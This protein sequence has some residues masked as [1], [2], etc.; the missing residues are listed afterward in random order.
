ML[1]DLLC[2]HLS[3]HKWGQ[4]NLD[5]EA[6]AVSQQVPA[7]ALHP[8]LEPRFCSLYMSGLL[9]GR[10]LDYAYGGYLEDRSFLL[11]QSYL[12][13]GSMIHLG[14]DYMVAAGTR[15]F[16][17]RTAKV[18]AFEIDPDQEGGWGG[19]AILATPEVIYVICHLN[20]KA[21][22][23]RYVGQELEKGSLVGFTGKTRENGGWWPHIHIQCLRPEMLPELLAY[24]IDG[25]G[26]KR[27]DNA[28][29]FPDPEQVLVEP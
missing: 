17:P 4:L 7:G 11:A 19:R 24:K 13:P 16:L 10:K 23:R 25:Y 2:P 6:R 29:R 22:I 1:H 15:V 18:V 12:T 5:Q 26:E 21:I 3:A 14:I 9:A 28:E 27:A 20:H 8:F